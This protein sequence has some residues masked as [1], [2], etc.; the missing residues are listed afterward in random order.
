MKLIIQPYNDKLGKLLIED[1]LSGRYN[2]FTFLVAY[3]KLSGVDALYDSIL[4]FRAAKGSVHAIVGIDQEN[5][6]FEALRAILGITEDLFIFHNIN[7]SSTFHPKVYILAGEKHGKIYVGSNNLTGSGLYSNYEI[8]SC[9]EFDLTVPEQAEDFA[10]MVRALSTFCQEGP[11]CRQASEALIKRLYESHLVCT[12]R[13]ICIMGKKGVSTEQTK[14]NFGE[15]PVFGVEPITGRTRKHDFGYLAPEIE[16]REEYR[17]VDA[18]LS[19]GVIAPS[20]STGDTGFIKRFYK[21]LSKNDVD[22]KSSPG[23]I[24]IPIGYKSFF[25]PLSEPQRTPKGAMQSEHYFAIKYENNGE[26]IEN[27]RVIFYVPAPFHPRKNSEVRFAL[28]NREI[29]KTFEQGD[30]LVFSQAAKE[31]RGKYLYTVKR[32]PHDSAEAAVYSERF[33]WIDE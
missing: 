1:L 33:A 10:N 25:E 6:S 14:N 3:A 24:V 29:F 4:A 15:E 11:C 30:V 2:N 18:G 16:I 13:E 8:A 26:I 12:E 31:D 7:L 9:G 5:T 28:R 32:I 20:V 23:Q 27:A 19:N 21:H 22:L 17:A